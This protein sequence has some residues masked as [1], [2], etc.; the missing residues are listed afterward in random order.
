MPLREPGGNTQCW[1]LRRP[2]YA[3]AFASPI[4]HGEDVAYIRIHP[5]TEKSS[6]KLPAYA[7]AAEFSAERAIM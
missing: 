1:Q 5:K 6:K 3:E 7:P 4:P 2:T